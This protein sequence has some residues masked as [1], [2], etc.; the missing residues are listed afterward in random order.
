MSLDNSNNVTLLEWACFISKVKLFRLIQLAFL[1]KSNVFQYNVFAWCKRAKLRV[2]WIKTAK[3]TTLQLNNLRMFMVYW[4]HQKIPTLKSRDR[5]KPLF[6]CE[7]I[8]KRPKADLDEDIFQ[9]LH[10]FGSFVPAALES[11]D[12]IFEQLTLVGESLDVH[13][14]LIQ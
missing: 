1:W 5:L 2:P 7:N 8:I 14:W 13:L 12:F 4:D 6:F 3:K 9:V 11:P 10:I